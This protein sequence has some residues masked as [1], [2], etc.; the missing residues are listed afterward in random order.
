MVDFTM[1]TDV[2]THNN[3]ITITYNG[4]D[5]DMEGFYYMLNGYKAYP[6]DLNFENGKATISVPD[7]IAAIAF[8]LKADGKYLDND[9]KGYLFPILD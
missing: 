9:K 8:N 2:V 7:S 6:Q 3:P 4:E 5:Q 1:S